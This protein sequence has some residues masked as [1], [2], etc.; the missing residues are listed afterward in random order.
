MGGVGRGRHRALPAQH[1]REGANVDAELLGRVVLEE[2]AQLHGRHGEAERLQPERDVLRQQQPGAAHVPRTEEVGRAPQLLLEDQPQLLEHLRR[3]QRR[4]RQ[5]RRRPLLP[6]LLA[7]RQRPCARLEHLEARGILLRAHPARPPV[8]RN[9]G[10]RRRASRRRR[11]RRMRR[12]TPRVV[13]L[14][15]VA[16]VAVVVEGRQRAAAA[17]HELAPRRAQV[18]LAP[19]QLGL[20]RLGAPLSREQLGAQP[21]DGA[22]R[23]R[24]GRRGALLDVAAQRRLVALQ[25]PL[26]LAERRGERPGERQQRADREGLGGRHLAQRGVELLQHLQ[27]HRAA[28]ERVG[29]LLLADAAGV[30]HGG[31]GGGRLGRHGGGGRSAA[32]GRAT[33][34]LAP[35][36]ALDV[37]AGPAAHRRRRGGLADH[38]SRAQQHNHALVPR[39]LASEPQAAA[40]RPPAGLDGGRGAVSL[41]L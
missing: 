14:Q 10:M 37:R 28:R 11:V 12:R 27:L 9:A 16:V 41:H 21:C 19:A 23:R 25:Q 38:A 7:R 6:R 15:P 13:V 1:P 5:R 34:E 39:R 33:G 20:Q 29:R 26:L 17:R 8:R 31:G 32:G 4:Q 3:L 30:A 36:L 18:R 24:R 40:Q 35:P 2:R 22:R